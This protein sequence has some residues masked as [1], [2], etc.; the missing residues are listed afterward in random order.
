[1]CLEQTLL[2]PLNDLKSR[3]N[4]ILNSKSVQKVHSTLYASEKW[5]KK[6]NK[7]MYKTRCLDKPLQIYM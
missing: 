5:K 3:V 7:V 2:L 6:N 4:V 1:M